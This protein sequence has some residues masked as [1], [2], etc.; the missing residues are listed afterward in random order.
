[1]V[2]ATVF[3]HRHPLAYV[4]MTFCNN[5]KTWIFCLFTRPA[6]QWNIHHTV[7][8]KPVGTISVPSTNKFAIGVYICLQ[9]D[10][11]HTPFV[12]FIV[13]GEPVICNRHV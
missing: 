12:C 3:T 1:M 4:C 2:A 13:P 5:G 9:A 6:N 11:L 8:N 7:N 10:W